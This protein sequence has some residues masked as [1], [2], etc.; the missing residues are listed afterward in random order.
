MNLRSDLRSGI[1]KTLAWYREQTEVEA[2]AGE[3][4]DGCDH[5]E[6]EAHEDRKE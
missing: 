5:K 2:S 4:A 1:L 6:H 3:T